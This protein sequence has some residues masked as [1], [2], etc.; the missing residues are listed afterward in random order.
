VAYG[1]YRIAGRDKTVNEVY[2]EEKGH[3][4]PLPSIAFSNIET[5]PAR[6]TNTNRGH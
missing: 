3:L 4:I 1:A 2:E 6:W 5:S